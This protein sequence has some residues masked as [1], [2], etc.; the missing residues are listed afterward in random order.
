MGCRIQY[1]YWDKAT[2]EGFDCSPEIRLRSLSS[3]K[4]DRVRLLVWK[5]CG[6]DKSSWCSVSSYIFLSCI[7]CPNTTFWRVHLSCSLWLPHENEVSRHFS[8]VFC[9]TTFEIFLCIS[10]VICKSNEVDSA[11][12]GAGK[13][14]LKTSFHLSSGISFFL[15][16]KIRT[17]PK[18]CLDADNKIRVVR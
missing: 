9:T 10:P 3:E 7:V 18:K 5:P 11:M 4:W 14:L 8:N 12:S 17:T 1:G 13:K 2:W 16:Q 15:A 6:M